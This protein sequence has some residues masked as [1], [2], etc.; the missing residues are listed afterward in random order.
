VKVY[1]TVIFY[2]NFWPASI[3]PSSSKC[4]RVYRSIKNELS[5]DRFKAILSGILS[6]ML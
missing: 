4:S 3:G 2:C 5:P 1:R 6:A